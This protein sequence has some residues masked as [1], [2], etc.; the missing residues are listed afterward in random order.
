VL[1]V[2]D[3]P[4][5]RW[6]IV[7]TLTQAGDVVF[8]AADAEATLRTLAACGGAVDVVLLDLCLPDCRDL[9]LLARIRRMSPAAVVVMTAFACPEVACEAVRQGVDRIIGKPFDLREVAAAVHQ[10]A[11]PTQTSG[12]AAR[13]PMTQPP[14]LE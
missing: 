10:A 7:E 9:T 5:I 12:V 1:V 11:S 3:E 6:A 2:D 14:A 4:L 13:G 8:E